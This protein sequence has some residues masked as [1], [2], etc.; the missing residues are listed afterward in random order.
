M[1]V[2]GCCRLL[3][4]SQNL[5]FFACLL[6]T[7]AFILLDTF[8]RRVPS[9]DLVRGSWIYFVTCRL[10]IE[11]RQLRSTERRRLF[12]PLTKVMRTVCVCSWRPEP[13]WRS[14][15]MCVHEFSLVCF[16]LVFSFGFILIF[17]FSCVFPFFL[18]MNMWVP[19]SRRDGLRLSVCFSKFCS[20]LHDS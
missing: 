16:S 8:M 7:L 3:I 20:P 12:W 10:F 15:T 2:V 4:G 6:H 19:Y 14:K 1:C 17:A 9:V 18:C 13:T 11:L 5:I